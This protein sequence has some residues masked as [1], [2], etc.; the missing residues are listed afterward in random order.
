MPRTRSRI[1]VAFS[2]AAKLRSVPTPGRVEGVSRLRTSRPRRIPLAWNTQRI[3]APRRG[4]VHAW[5]Q[6]RILGLPRK[7]QQSESDRARGLA[8]ATSDRLLGR[9]PMNPSWSPR[10]CTNPKCCSGTWLTDHDGHCIGYAR[11]IIA[12]GNDLSMTSALEFTPA[13]QAKLVEMLF[14]ATPPSIRRQVH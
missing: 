11:N 8:P 10:W 4:G 13:A 12:S 3:P 1:S 14:S 2:D 6:P 9:S 7:V 5:R